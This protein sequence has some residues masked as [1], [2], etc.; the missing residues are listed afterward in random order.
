MAILGLI[1]GIWADRIQ[2]GVESNWTNPMQNTV[3]ASIAPS[4]AASAPHDLNAWKYL[5]LMGGAWINTWRQPA[6]DAVAWWCW[7]MK[8]T[9]RD[10]IR[11]AYHFF[12]AHHDPDSWGGGPVTGAIG[13]RILEEAGNDYYLSVVQYNG[14]VWVPVGT[15]GSGSLSKDNDY[16]VTLELDRSGGAGNHT[17]KLWIGDSD[18]MLN[19]GATYFTKDPTDVDIVLT[20]TPCI[21]N[22]EAIGGKGAGETNDVTVAEVFA[23]DD[24]IS[25]S[26]S[27]RVDYYGAA[28]QPHVF[29]IMPVADSPEADEDE[30]TIVGNP[31]GCPNDAYRAVDDYFDD[32]DQAN[33]R[34]T[35]TGSGLDQLFDM[36]EDY[37]DGTATIYGIMGVLSCF[38]LME[39][40]RVGK[41]LMYCTDEAD[42]VEYTLTVSGSAVVGTQVFAPAHQTPAGNPWS[43][44]KLDVLRAG[45]RSTDGLAFKRCNLFLVH[46]LGLNLK[47]PANNSAC[48][49]AAGIR[50]WPGAIF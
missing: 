38:E 40:R 26:P 46:V 22:K 29:S 12:Y 42:P 25:G 8:Q 33:D 23:Y 16:Y 14:V 18:E 32:D 27:A 48:P 17:V 15:T 47:Q 35:A 4:Q 7:H 3:Y 11:D 50:R 30:W 45:I 21:Y 19:G 13:V 24:D 34:L 41:G 10:A 37:E 20:G 9:G 36:S 2:I 31:A 39:D 5:N 28:S 6:S 43:V 44:A 1:S 49:A